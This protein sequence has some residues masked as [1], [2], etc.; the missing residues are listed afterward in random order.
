MAVQNESIRVRKRRFLDIRTDTATEIN[1][2]FKRMLKTG[3]NWKGK[4][5][6]VHDEGIVKLQVTP[7]KGMHIQ[8]P[9]LAC[10]LCSQPMPAVLACCVYRCV[11]LLFSTCKLQAKGM[12]EWPC[13]W[14]CSLQLQSSA[15]RCAWHVQ[16]RQRKVLWR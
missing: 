13:T 6:V 3:R 1:Q 2:V 14:T 10:L 4:I 8:H 11:I 7:N 12:I 5:E 15:E 16:G 9:L